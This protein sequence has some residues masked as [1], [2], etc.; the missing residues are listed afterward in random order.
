MYVKHRVTRLFSLVTLLTMVCSLVINGRS[1]TT[2]SAATRSVDSITPA[3]A[4]KVG[5]VLGE[6]KGETTPGRYI[7]EL[8]DAPLATYTGGVNKLRGTSP[9]VTGAKLDI[10]STA[11]KAYRTYLANK[12][13]ETL[14]GVNQIVGKNVD[15][16]YTYDAAYN[17]FVVELTPAQAAEVAKLPNVVQVQREFMRYP[18]TDVGPQWIDADE[19]WSGVATEAYVAT[20]LGA[21]EVPPVT[22]TGM[23]EVTG[24]YDDASNTLQ[25]TA[26]LSDITPT[27][28]HVHTGSFTE[29]GGVV[30][31]FT[32][33]TTNVWTLSTTL[34]L[35]NEMDLRTG[36]LYVNFH[37]AAN[38]GG[39][40]RGQL[41]GLKG[42]GMLVGVIDTGINTDHPSFAATGEDGYTHINPFGEGNYKGA[43]DPTNL[44]DVSTNPSGY[45]ATITCNSKLVGAWTWPET[46]GSAGDDFYN[47]SPEDE[48]GHGSHTAS[49]TAGNVVN[50]AGLNGVTFGTISGVAPH[51][52]IIAYDACRPGGCP[53]GALVASINQAV[54]DG[55]DVINYSIGGGSSNPWT[56]ADATAFRNARAAG[57]MV[58]TSAGNSGPGPDTVGSPA[59]APW[60]MAVGAATHNRLAVNALINMSGGD[61]TPPADI[62]GKSVTVG[63]G[64]APIVYAGDFPNPNAPAG[65][66]P[67]QCT[68]PY[69]A[70]TFTGQIVVCDRGVGGRVAKGQNVLAGGAGGYVLA[71]DEPNGNSLVGDAHVLPAVHISYA[72]G[73]VLKAWLA[74]GNGHMATIEGT[75]LDYSFS[76]GD[77][78]ASFSSRGSDTSVPDIIKPDVAAPGVD[79]IAAVQT[80]DSANPGPNPEFGII[81]GTSMASPHAAGASTLVRMLHPGWTPAEVQ[82]AL[83]LTGIHEVRKEDGS[84]PADPFDFGGG[85]INVARAATAG[86]VLNETDANYVA[87]DPA[88]NGDPS[89]LNL[90][91]LG[92]ADCLDVCTW[93]RT[94]QSTKAVTT[95]WTI[96]YTSTDNVMLSASPS[97]FELGPMA[98]QTIVITADV[99]AL[100]KDAWVFGFV[101]F[102]ED[103]TMAPDAAMPV[104]VV[105]VGGILPNTLNIQTRRDSG[106]YPVDGVV[107]SGSSNLSFAAH[108]LAAATVNDYYILQDS[109]NGDAFDDLTDG[110]IT[111]T[112]DVPAGTERLVVETVDSTAIDMDLYVTFDA[113][114][115]GIPQSG[116]VVCSSTTA[117]AIEYCDL[118]MPAA[119]TYIVVVQ[120]WDDS[121]TGVADLVRLSVGVVPS[122]SSGN[123]SVT[124]P[125]TAVAGD[126][127][128]IRVM[129]DLGSA[130][131]GD[132][133][134]GSFDITDGPGGN[135]FGTVPVN[136]YRIE[137]DVIKTVSDTM[138]EPGAPVTLTYTITVNPNVMPEA[139]H[140]AITD[141]LPAGTTYVPGSVTGG[142][143]VTGNTLTWNGVMDSPFSALG[144]YVV[145]TNQNDANCDTGF[146]GYVDL[147]SLGITVSGVTGDDA[148]YTAFTNSSNFTY[149][150]FDQ[151]SVGVGI[152]TNGNLRSLAQPLT[153]SEF[154][155]QP[156]PTAADPN[157]VIAAFWDDLVVVTDAP[158][159]RGVYLASVA[160]Q[161]IALIQ[162]KDVESEANPADRYDFEVVMYP[163]GNDNDI[164]IAYNTMA[165]PTNSATVGIE[166]YTGTTGTEYAYNGTGGPISNGLIVCMNYAPPQL[167]PV[168]ITYQ[169][170]VD[171][172]VDGETYTNSVDSSVAEP[173]YMTETTSVD[174]NV[175]QSAPGISLVK[176][177]ST[178]DDSCQTMTTSEITV[179]AGTTVYYCFAVTNTGN[180]VLPLHDLVDD[181]LGTIFTDVPFMLDPGATFTTTEVVVTATIDM[182]TTNVATWTGH[183]ADDSVT[184]SA[185][186]SATVHVEQTTTNYVVYLPVVLKP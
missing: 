133:F 38:S 58:A 66:D 37:T 111:Q 11:S 176:T 122:A 51:A 82:S 184:A 166:D 5:V 77:I 17:G 120:N 69:P 45:N 32:M 30:A 129:W 88:A 138:I 102:T 75:T 23:G 137:D 21:N 98:E 57:V 171:N 173:G 28:G 44:P 154:A 136:L 162:Y 113:N 178:V 39:E 186:A 70:G 63:Y 83:T 121:A 130:M 181:Q 134:Y 42:E 153:G 147:P 140:Y 65:D 157:G 128:S 64:P 96:S 25:L 107:T 97:T 172:P 71:N 79:I 103:N 99:T 183:N 168:V 100:P 62:T 108:G 148:L 141:T 149:N 48:D 150:I 12:R 47:N 163:E 43:C 2:A 175:A 117:T 160:S 35:A 55:V 68:A 135:S 104:A 127:Y 132:I 14:K 110:V 116:E 118:A 73:V 119:G 1:A 31:P 13:T 112:V 78:M 26:V 126:P 16:V 155:N 90:A 49:T 92:N 95:A 19:I 33:V 94:I 60:I 174:V 124:G 87:A 24:S 59:D 41:T 179:T 8:S 85:R 56:D 53:G 91:T 10:N 152:D 7:V 89:T 72:D 158:I 125:A 34:N 170:T 167:D 114:N 165:G 123:M 159:T 40:I 156:I 109:S 161:G 46:R 144:S 84:T 164:V 131:Q 74:S 145:T 180:E 177:V 101:Q 142:A 76:N 146:G 50:G 143:S 54:M 18:Q 151:D 106:S 182:E 4:E 86:F 80:P 36:D 20:L 22:T 52:N 115:D 29:T 185:T 6:K 27:M 9:A 93:T 169:V 3:K 139:L 61:T 15:V 105:P 81:S 67:A